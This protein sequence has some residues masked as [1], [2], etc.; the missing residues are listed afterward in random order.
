MNGSTRPQ[1]TSGTTDSTTWPQEAFTSEQ[2]NT[3][4]NK[5][6]QK[7]YYSSCQAWPINTVLS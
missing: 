2:S 4:N 1:V 5:K 6:T 7:E 3:I